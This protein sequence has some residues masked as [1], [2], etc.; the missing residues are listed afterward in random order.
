MQSWYTPTPPSWPKL[1]TWPY[2]PPYH[3][4][5]MNQPFQQYVPQQPQWKNP[6]QGWR[7]Q[8]YKP[9]ALKPLPQPQPQ[10]THAAPPKLPQIPVQ[11]N[12]NLKNRK[13][14]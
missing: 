8:H 3:P 12:M 1:P 13:A 2:N 10:L 14:H 6:S 4:Q 9:P 11:P 7:P 5:P